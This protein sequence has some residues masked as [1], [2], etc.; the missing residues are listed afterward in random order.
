[1]SEKNYDSSRA[2]VPVRKVLDEAA[3]AIADSQRTIIQSAIPDILGAAAGAG[4]GALAGAGIV[5]AGAATGTAGAAALTSGL[6][7]A[8][9]WVGGG[10]AAGIGVAAAPAVILAV[11]G[12]ALVS[13]WN[14]S[15]LDKQ[16]R[17]LLQEALRKQAAIVDRLQKE[18]RA[19]RA[20]ADYLAA[21]NAKLQEVIRNLREDLDD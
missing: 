13:W 20:R 6:A 12:Y 1:M 14:A 8:G 10:M 2:L 9:A 4:A 11:G 19:N 3:A 21:L 5:A 17:A 7:S 18:S 16:R 15:E